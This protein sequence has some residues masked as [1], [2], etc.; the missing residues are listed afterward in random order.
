MPH[1]TTWLST[2]PTVYEPSKDVWS[3]RFAGSIAN[4]SLFEPERNITEVGN[5]VWLGQG[6]RVK[7]G[8]RIGDGA[9]VAAGAVV[10]KD[11]P[12]YAIVGGVPAKV[13]KMRFDDSTIKRL[14]DSEWWKYDLSSLGDVDFSDVKSALAVIEPLI[15]SGRIKKYVSPIVKAIDFYPYSRACFFFFDSSRG[16]RIKLF[17]IWL[18]HRIK[19][20]KGEL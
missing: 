10:T 14:L 13:I 11:V 5:D 1:P 7:K 4:Q 16:I 12:P 15:I 3:N 19:R 17:G 9:I 20:A 6:V 8:V 18:V 2:S